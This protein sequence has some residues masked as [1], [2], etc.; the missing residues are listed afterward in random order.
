ME[1]SSYTAGPEG[2]LAADGFAGAAALED[3]AGL[4]AATGFFAGA[5]ALTAAGTIVAAVIKSSGHMKGI[6]R[7][8]KYEKE[9]DLIFT[10]K[11]FNEIEKP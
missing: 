4:A 2:F 7:V 8:A 9:E 11:T 1:F 6:D 3:A 10:G 5:A